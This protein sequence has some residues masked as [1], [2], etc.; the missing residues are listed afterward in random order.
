MTFLLSREFAKILMTITLCLWS[1]ISL[2]QDVVGTWTGTV[3]QPGSGSYGIVMTIASPSGG[4]TEYSSLSCGGSLSGGG[5]GGVYNF[6]ETITHG[7]VG[8]KARGGCIDGNIKVVLSGSDRM[9]W[10]WTGSYQGKSYYASGKLS[11]SGASP[12]VGNCSVCGKALVSDI[13]YG[14]GQSQGLRNYVLE[15][16]QKFS[17]CSRSGCQDLCETGMLYNNLPSCD[18][19]N[20]PGYRACVKSMWEGTTARCR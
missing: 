17:N 1:S 4:T 16:R 14:L 10:E 9:F 12:S 3:D 7:R 13:G 5:S 19:F 2:A 15:A 20:E 8:Q 18:G 6:R 11:R